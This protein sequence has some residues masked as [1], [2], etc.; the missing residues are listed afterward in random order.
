MKTLA[1]EGTVQEG[2]DYPV[3]FLGGPL[4]GAIKRGVGS[5]YVA[6]KFLVATDNVKGNVAFKTAEEYAY[7]VHRFCIQSGPFFAERRV[8]LPAGSRASTYQTRTLMRGSG[9][10]IK[11]H[12]PDFME[13]FDRWLARQIAIHCTWTWESADRR[14]ALDYLKRQIGLSE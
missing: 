13:E 12:E 11:E 2:E 6:Q 7:D 8:A 10:S 14:D 1:I 4:D 5:R 9:W 3:L